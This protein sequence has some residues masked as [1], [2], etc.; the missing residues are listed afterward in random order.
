[1]IAESESVSHSCWI[2]FFP[3]GKLV[4]RKVI[5][6]QGTNRNIDVIDRPILCL[7]LSPYCC[8]S[9][10]EDIIKENMTR[11]KPKNVSGDCVTTGRSVYL[12]S[13]SRS[14]AIGSLYRYRLSIRIA[15]SISDDSFVRTLACRSV[16]RYLPPA[17][18][19]SLHET[20]SAGSSHQQ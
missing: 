4:I 20:K 10:R 9:S 12:D 1:M 7:T 3:G 17:G 5:E 13:V 16:S 2:D 6:C 15:F 11:G 8:K 19:L 14:C 18:D